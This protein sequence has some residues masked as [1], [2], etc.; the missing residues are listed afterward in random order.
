MRFLRWLFVNRETGRVTVMQIPNVPL[1]VF[2][3]A[4]AGRRLLHPV[5]R[6]GSAV[7]VVAA[8]SLLV[9]AVDEVFRGVNP[10]RRIL[11]AAVAAFTVWSLVAR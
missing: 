5:G 4:A 6:I 2:L 9:W 7:N 11:G 3:V 10:F 1:C 8:G